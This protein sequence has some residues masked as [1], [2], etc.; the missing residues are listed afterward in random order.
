VGNRSK[1]KGPGSLIIS[2]KIARSSHLWEFRTAILFTFLVTDPKD[3][4]SFPR[5][6]LQLSLKFLSLLSFSLIFSGFLS[7]FSFFFI[8]SASG[9]TPLLQP[10]PQFQ[11][12]AQALRFLLKH[13]HRYHFRLPVLLFL[14]FRFQ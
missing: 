8:C 5:Y 1:L 11:A 9:N 14:R 4:L 6:Y 3:P 10:A 12:Q 2:K 13:L 7:L